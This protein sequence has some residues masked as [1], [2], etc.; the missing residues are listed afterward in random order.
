VKKLDSGA[1][2]IT[3]PPAAPEPVRKPG[4]GAAGTR[5]VVL[6]GGDV[7]RLER[8]ATALAGAHIDT[9]TV[10]VGVAALDAVA[11]LEPSA[12][13]IDLGRTA[14]EG[15]R[16]AEELRAS[17]FAKIPVLLAGARDGRGARRARAA[18][19]GSY[20]SR[21]PPGD[22]AFLDRVIETVT[23]KSGRPRR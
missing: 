7:L 1:A 10:E 17:Q 23:A 22:G 5:R 16:L 3:A 2:R 19:P 12:V 11:R 21:L 4:R 14:G 13:V 6:V 8:A 18:A 20:V 15:L 9:S